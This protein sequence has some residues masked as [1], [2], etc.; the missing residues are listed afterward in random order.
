MADFVVVDGAFLG[1]LTGAVSSASSMT[2][3][4]FDTAG[5]ASPRALRGALVREVAVAMVMVLF[6]FDFQNAW[7]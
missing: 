5:A 1:F 2:R 4:L 7:V 6:M 3:F